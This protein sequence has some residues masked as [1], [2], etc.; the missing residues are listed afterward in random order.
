LQRCYNANFIEANGFSVEER[1]VRALMAVHEQS[2]T[3]GGPDSSGVHESIWHLLLPRLRSELRRWYR[4]P[5][6]DRN[7]AAVALRDQLS[8]L[9]REK[10]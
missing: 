1:Q 5:G 2:Y 4:L 7:P 8:Q 6:A 10:L 9:A 3:L